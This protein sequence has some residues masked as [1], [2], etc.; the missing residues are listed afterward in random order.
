[1]ARLKEFDHDQALHSAIR[2]FSRKGYAATSTEDLMQEMGIGRQSMYD[3]FGVKRSLFLQALQTYVT[4]SCGAILNE[5]QR[6]GPPLKVLQEALIAF[7]ERKDMASSDGCMGLNAI[8]EFGTSDAEVTRTIRSA[9][10]QQRRAIRNLL[11][12]AVGQGGLSE[13]DVDSAADFIDATLAGIRYA[14][15]AGKSRKALRDMAVFAG[16]ALS[17]A[18]D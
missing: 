4:A 17:R 8:S 18:S 3:T 14:A 16:N 10:E 15:K 5:L 2:A 6:P 12:N 13:A 11:N 7:A 1:M 9:A